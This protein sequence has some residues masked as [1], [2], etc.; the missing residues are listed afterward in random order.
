VVSQAVKHHFVEA[1]PEIGESRVQPLLDLLL[2]SSDAA[3]QILDLPQGFVGLSRNEQ[4]L[5]LLGGG[6]RLGV[7]GAGDLD[8]DGTSILIARHVTE[9]L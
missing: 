7:R 5:L 8:R 6:L 3:R 1:S 9:T 4:K 2:K